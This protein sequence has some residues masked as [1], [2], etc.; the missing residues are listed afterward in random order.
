MRGKM[1]ARGRRVSL[2]LR[3]IRA[4]IPDRR[5]AGSHYCMAFCSRPDLLH[6]D[7][8]YALVTAE[9]G[10]FKPAGCDFPHSGCRAC[11]ADFWKDIVCRFVRV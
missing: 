10:A 9:S 11:R 6:D 5:L 2:P 4:P 1:G 8:K 7:W 3:I